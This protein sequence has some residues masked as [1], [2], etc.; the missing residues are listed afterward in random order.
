M[1][2]QEIQPVRVHLRTRQRERTQRGVR[3]DTGQGKDEALGLD[4]PHARR[5][6]GLEPSR[7]S[8]VR[9]EPITRPT[10]PR[11][12]TRST[13]WPG[14]RAG[15]SCLSSWEAVRR[16]PLLTG[17]PHCRAAALCFWSLCPAGKEDARGPKWRRRGPCGPWRALGRRVSRVRPT[18]ATGA[19]GRETKPR[20]PTEGCVRS[21]GRVGRQVKNPPHG[22]QSSGKGVDRERPRLAAQGQACMTEREAGV[23]AQHRGPALPAGAQ[24]D[25]SLPGQGDSS[26]GQVEVAGAVTC[27]TG[28]G[29]PS[30]DRKPLGKGSV[31]ATAVLQTWDMGGPAHAGPAGAPSQAEEDPWGPGGE[32]APRGPGWCLTPS[33]SGLRHTTT[34]T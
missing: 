6:A 18:G 31:Q 12:I 4:M 5:A 24:L 25:A 17:P 21:Q 23:Y 8:W 29:C 32:W 2:N 7:P 30:P 14:W 3:G 26:K 11:T 10:P 19:S 34:T 15:G 9:T 33:I 22:P 20:Q 16:R 13:R 27:G 28:S 1:H